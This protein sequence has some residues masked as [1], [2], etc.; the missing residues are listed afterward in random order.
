MKR[1]APIALL[2]LAAC[3]DKTALPPLP[4]P[5]PSMCNSYTPYN[6]SKAAAAVEDIA[7]IRAHNSN[8]SAFYECI[9]NHPKLDPARKGGPR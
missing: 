2:L 1:L 3:P 7:N 6:Y 4:A 8:E 5:G 9:T